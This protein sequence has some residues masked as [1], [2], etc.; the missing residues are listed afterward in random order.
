MITISHLSCVQ[1]ILGECTKTLCIKLV[2]HI[3]FNSLIILNHNGCDLYAFKIFFISTHFLVIFIFFHILVDLSLTLH[4]SLRDRLVRVLD[5]VAVFLF[6]GHLGKLTTARW[7]KYLFI[8]FI[9]VYF[10]STTT[11]I[12][13]GLFRFDRSNMCHFIK[14]LSFW[15]KLHYWILLFVNFYC[16]LFFISSFCFVYFIIYWLSYFNRLFLFISLCFIFFIIYWIFCF[17]RL[18]FF[19]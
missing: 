2:V 17:Y 14:T 10:F 13:I 6:V 12:N 11:A 5:F 8:Y 4:P 9:F 1:V 7:C 15:T 16:L 18:I 3:L 19:F